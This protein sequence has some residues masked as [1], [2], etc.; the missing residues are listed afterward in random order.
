M[1]QACAATPAASD[2]AADIAFDAT[3]VSY[4]GFGSFHSDNVED[5]IAVPAASYTPP[6]DL[7]DYGKYFVG[8]ALTERARALGRHL[9]YEEVRGVFGRSIRASHFSVDPSWTF[10]NHGAF[11]GALR[12]S[13]TAKRNYEDLMEAQPLAFIDRLLEWDAA[14]FL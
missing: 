4:K 11:G 2:A 8:D 10:V 9:T 13:L 6:A 5:M 12:Q 3:E 7:P 1:P 14:S